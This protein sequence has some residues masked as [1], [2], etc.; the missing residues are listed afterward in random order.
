MRG[1][2]KS[3]KSR[4][5]CIASIKTV[6][7]IGVRCTTAARGSCR[8]AE[9]GCNRKFLIRIMVALKVISLN[10]LFDRLQGEAQ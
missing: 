6:A 7:G 2:R 3:S 10:D 4:D 5:S 9:C 1:K 8:H